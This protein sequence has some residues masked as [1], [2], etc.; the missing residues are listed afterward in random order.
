MN[1]EINKLLENAIKYQNN[2]SE[3]E[4]Y[5]Y[6]NEACRQAEQVYGV[7]HP[8]YAIALGY[9]GLFLYKS[10]QDRNSIQYCESAR[11]I[12][13]K[14]GEVDSQEYRTLLNNL[15]NIYSSLGLKSKARSIYTSILKIES[16]EKKDSNYA[17]TLV[18]RGS[19]HRE[20]GRYHEALNDLK[21]AKKIY[22]DNGKTRTSDY[23]AM[24]N[25]IGLYYIE[26]QNYNGSI[27]YFN[28]ALILLKEIGLENG[29]DYLPILNN[30]ALAHQKKGDYEKSIEIY[31]DVLNLFRSKFGEN[32]IDITNIYD[33]LSGIYIKCNNYEKAFELIIKSSKINEKYLD[34]FAGFLS[35][36]ELSGPINQFQLHVHILFS[37]LQQWKNPPQKCINFAFNVIFRR[38]A[39]VMDSYIYRRRMTSLKCD[40]GIKND[41][42]R[43]TSTKYEIARMINTQPQDIE[44]FEEFKNKLYQLENECKILERNIAYQ[45]PDSYLENIKDIEGNEAIRAQL[46]PNSAVIEFIRYNSINLKK[47][48]PHIPKP[49][50]AVFILTSDADIQFVDLGSALEIENLIKKTIS[51]IGEGELIFP[52]LERLSDRI[53]SPISSAIDQKQHLFVIPDASLNLLPIGILVSD[54]KYLIEKTRITYLT[55]SRDLLK[56]KACE[57]QNQ[58]NPIIIADPDYDLVDKDDHS[59]LISTVDDQRIFS[60]PLKQFERLEGTRVEGKKIHSII[61]GELW[62]DANALESKLKNLHSPKILHIASHG[63]YLPENQKNNSHSLFRCSFVL[64]GVNSFIHGLP[65]P[66]EAEDGIVNAYEVA[67]LDLKS[68]DMVVLSA[69]ETGLGDSLAGEGVFGFRRSFALAG[70]KTLVISLWSIPDEETKELM[71]SFY[72]NLKAGMERAE[73]L[74]KAQLSVKTNHS[75]PYY[76][77]AFILQGVSDKILW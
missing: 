19:I 57:P 45:I 36:T 18:N 3:T 42:G 4:A 43:L 26:L 32:H 61:G 68:T 14:A 31:T 38:K 41:L 27:N 74:Q 16:K 10:K 1:P 24:L 15:V 25:H 51:E 48:T 5:D 77:G 52:T 20:M 6:F 21:E 76:W 8:C 63:Y 65:L 12:M 40:E 22:E 54:G 67:E 75:N 11:E 35:D 46:P 30:I 50:Y 39:F 17:K 33:N 23:A 29:P 7:D 9:F 34:D 56:N 2:G 59:N 28:K 64:A 53:L 71:V 66:T 69:C 62:L 70:A 13:E 72:S 73:A 55:S 60:E 37:L 44:N 58:T 49:R 47:K